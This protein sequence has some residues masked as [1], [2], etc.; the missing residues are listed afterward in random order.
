MSNESKTQADVA[1][2][3]IAPVLRT[4]GLTKRYGKARGIEDL[5]L[6]VAQGE[7]FGFL[8]PNGSGK[9]TTIR[10]LLDLLHPTRGRAELFGLDSGR[11]SLAIRRRLGY[12]PGDVA[13]YEDMTAKELLDLVARIRSV[14]CEKN[15]RSL[16]ERLGMDLRARI[17]AC[18]KGT[19]QKIAIIQALMHDPELLILDEPTLG[20]DPLVQREFYQILLEQK[21]AGRTVFLSSHIL[22]EVERVC[23][24]VGIIREGRLVD[25]EH[26]SDLKRKKVRKMELVLARS[27]TDAD[28]AQLKMEGVELVGRHGN[29]MELA[30]HGNIERL[31][32]ILSAMPVEDLV[33][34]E[35]TLED[36]FMEFY[37]DRRKH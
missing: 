17:R 36:T 37:G 29:R 26:V 10:L 23:D 30:V 22:T 3:P 27:V 11:D 28:V 1:V 12:L 5:D 13:L 4:S 34:P 20:L 21:A 31:L 8:G 24:R 15:Q 32:S 33:F 14:D 18:S 16:A 2:P 9:T 7:I 35:A 19:K 6:E 25:V